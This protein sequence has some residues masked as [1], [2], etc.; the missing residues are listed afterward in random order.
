MISQFVLTNK[1]DR[2]KLPPSFLLIFYQIN[3]IFLDPLFLKVEGTFSI[4]LLIKVLFFSNNLLFLNNKN[5]FLCFVGFSGVFTLFYSFFYIYLFLIFAPIFCFFI[6][7]IFH[8]K[9]SF[10]QSLCQIFTFNISNIN[11]DSTI[12]I[13][14]I[15]KRCKS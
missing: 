10:N 3:P 11:K 1:K 13:R 9:S 6:S 2:G 7:I 4:N 5:L 12:F 8:C 14:M 15:L